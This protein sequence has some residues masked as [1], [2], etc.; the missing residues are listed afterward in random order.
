MQL[1]AKFEKI[2]Y[3]GFRATLNFHR[4]T[5]IIQPSNLRLK[6]Q[7]KKS[8]SWILVFT[9]GIDFEKHLSLTCELTTSRQKHFSIH[10][11]LPA[12][13]QGSERVSSKAKHLDFSEPTPRKTLLRRISEHSDHA[14]T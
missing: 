4:L 9:K 2:L 7:T 14:F 12:T 5:G 3:M 11:S 6:Y 1:L 10:I 8:Y 13:H